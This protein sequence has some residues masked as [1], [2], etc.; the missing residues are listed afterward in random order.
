MSKCINVDIL[1]AVEQRDGVEAVVNKMATYLDDQ[2]F[3]TRECNDGQKSCG[4]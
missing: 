1:M 4:F 3:H 2:G